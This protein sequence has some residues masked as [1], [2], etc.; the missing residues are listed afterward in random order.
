[1]G[2]HSCVVVKWVRT[3]SLELAARRLECLRHDGDVAT[4][5]YGGA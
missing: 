2:L 5:Q 4:V 1:L 3:Q